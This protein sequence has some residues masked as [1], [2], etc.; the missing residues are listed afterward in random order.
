MMQRAVARDNMRL[1]EQA[2]GDLEKDPDHTDSAP[3]KP[4]S[5][6]GRKAKGPTFWDLAEREL[7]RLQKDFRDD[8]VGYKQ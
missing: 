5:G 8:A 3:A 1:A 4:G 2:E 6:R 7:L